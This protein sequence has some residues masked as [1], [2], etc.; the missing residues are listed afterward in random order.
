VEPIELPEDRANLQ[1]GN[2]LHKVLETF[3]KHEDIK[4]LSDFLQWRSKPTAPSEFGS[5]AHERL[6]GIARLIIPKAL[7][8]TA[9]FQHMTGRGWA[10]IAN[11][12]QSLCMQG[13]GPDL[14]STEV[15]LGK[16]EELPFNVG[17]RTINVHGTIDAVHGSNVFGPILMDYKTSTTPANKQIAAGLEPQLALYA[18]ALSSDGSPSLPGLRENDQDRV[19]VG[20]FNLS[21]GKPSFVALGESAKKDLLAGGIISKRSKPLSLDETIAAVRERWTGRLDAIAAASAFQ[22]D[23]S[24]C[25]MCSYAGVC[26]KDDPRYRDRIAQQKVARP[27]RADDMTDAQFSGAEEMQAE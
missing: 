3:F 20:Y 27:D 9:Q 16:T 12:W 13:W 25:T 23:P 21:E 26:R 11:F 2:W 24:D 10:S 8:R 5:W 1:T 17:G 4:G 7:S 6:D 19:A 22:A 15:L 18:K 14:V